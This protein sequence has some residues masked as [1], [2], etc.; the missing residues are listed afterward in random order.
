MISRPMSGP[1]A[2]DIIMDAVR[3]L[4]FETLPCEL[5]ECSSRDG[6]RYRLPIGIR[7]EWCLGKVLTSAL[8]NAG[9]LWTCRCPTN[10]QPCGLYVPKDLIRSKTKFRFNDDGTVRP[11]GKY[12]EDHIGPCQ[13][14]PCYHLPGCHYDR[15]RSGILVADWIATLRSAA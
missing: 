9:R 3:D 6:R 14:S 7:C 15:V 1:E 11:H 5:A 12:G 13:H 4:P 8:E 2:I 10:A